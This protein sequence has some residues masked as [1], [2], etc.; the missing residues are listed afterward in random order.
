MTIRT[1]YLKKQKVSKRSMNQIASASSADA[2]ARH[3]CR[4]QRPGGQMAL[5]LAVCFGLGIAILMS[6]FDLGIEA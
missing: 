6:F 5:V 2:E 1:V 3:G 4:F